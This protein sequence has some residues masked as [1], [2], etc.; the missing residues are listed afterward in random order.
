M[1]ASN[2]QYTVSRNN[3]QFGPYGF[4]ELKQYVNEGKVLNEDLVFD[5]ANWVQVGQILGFPKPSLNV[6]LV[7]PRNMAPSPQQINQQQAVNFMPL[8]APMFSSQGWIRFLSVLGFIASGVYVIAAIFSLIGAIGDGIGLVIVF[9]INLIAGFIFFYPSYLLWCY[10]NTIIQLRSG[11]QLGALKNAIELQARFWK[12]KGILALLSI[13]I[14]IV[15]FIL[16]LMGVNFLSLELNF[17]TDKSI[18]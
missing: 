10:A 6:P 1:N 13:I 18:N 14:I 11:F 16:I 12:F 8:L 17:P 9:I 15:I 2:A 3:E 4:E 5:G 7:A